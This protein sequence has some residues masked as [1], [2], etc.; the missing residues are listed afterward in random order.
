MTKLS[1]E[2][3]V[4]K[5]DSEEPEIVEIVLDPDTVY[6]V[7]ITTITKPYAIFTIYS[8]NTGDKPFRRAGGRERRL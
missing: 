7:T 3:E 5:E 2:Q 8:Y 1:S 6:K 4:E